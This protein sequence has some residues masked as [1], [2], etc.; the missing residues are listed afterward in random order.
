MLS[1]FQTYKIEVENESAY[2]K[3]PTAFRDQFEQ[4]ISWLNGIATITEISTDNFFSKKEIN[5]MLHNY[6]LALCESK[7]SEYGKQITQCQS[8][9]LSTDYF[10]LHTD[11]Y[12]AI[13]TAAD[14]KREKLSQNLVTILNFF[15]VS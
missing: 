11:Y 5:D 9:I 13:G 8:E 2:V 4:M 10:T 1:E 6:N 15:N 7:I 14:L 12:D 3:V